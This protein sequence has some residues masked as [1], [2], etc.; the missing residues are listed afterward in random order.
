MVVGTH[1]RACGVYAQ[2][3]QEEHEA[4]TGHVSDLSA[5]NADLA[6]YGQDQAAQV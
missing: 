4:V 6:A 3:A 5:D 1:K 2:E